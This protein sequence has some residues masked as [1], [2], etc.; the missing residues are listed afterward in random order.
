MTTTLSPPTGTPATSTT[1]S[2]GWNSRLASL[3]GLVIWRI[4]WI[5]GRCEKASR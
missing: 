4:S 3:K 5:A 2:R 1:V